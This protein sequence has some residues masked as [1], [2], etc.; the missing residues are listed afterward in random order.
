ML[1]VTSV[2]DSTSP[3]QIRIP[4]GNDQP[5]EYL[6]FDPYDPESGIRTSVSAS[7]SSGWKL[8][9]FASFAVVL[10]GGFNLRKTILWYLMSSDAK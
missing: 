3:V 6:S 2:G 5:D 1:V 8:Q 7:T 9:I 4:S 10:V